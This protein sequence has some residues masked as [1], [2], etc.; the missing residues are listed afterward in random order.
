MPR[1]IGLVT[2]LGAAALHDVVTA[3]QRRAPYLPVV[4][5]P[6]LVQGE[7]A[8]ASLVAALHQ[9]YA[10]AQQPGRPPGG[11]H[12]AGARWRLHGRFVGL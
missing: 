6:A 10:L 1:G 11:C 9:V 7:Q 12:L 2:S 4:L 5:V 3:L 8:P